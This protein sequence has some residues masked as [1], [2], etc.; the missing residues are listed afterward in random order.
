MPS[1]SE[2]Q[3]AVTDQGAVVRKLKESKAS[4]EELAVAIAE[5]KI[6]KSAVEAAEKKEAQCGPPKV[7]KQKFEN[8]MKRRFFYGPAFSLYGGVAG[9]YDY[10]PAGCAMKANMVNYWRNH[11]VVEEN[12]LEVEST[13]L[14]PEY[15]LKASGHVDRFCDFMV[16][17]VKTGDCYRADHLLEAHLEKLIEAKGTSMEKKEEMGSV[18]RQIDNYGLKEIGE[19]MRLYNCKAPVTNNELS[20]PAE[21]N[22]MFPTSIGPTGMLKGFMR[23]E[24]AQ[25]IFVNFKRLLEYNQDK[26]PFAGAQIGQSFRNEIAPRSGL[27]RVRE[28]CQAEIEHFIDP[29]DKTHPKFKKIKE[30]PVKF[31]SS[32]A[33]TSGTEVVEM[34]VGA[35]LDQGIIQSQTMG[36]FI[37]RIHQYLLAVGIPHTNLRFRQHM[38]NEMA[39][40]AC[41]C[42]DAECKTSYGWVEIVGCAD[43]SCFDLNAHAKATSHKLIAQKR[44]DEPI[45]VDVVEVTVNKAV[46]GKAFKKESGTVTTLLN[47]LSDEDKLRMKEKLES[48][49]TYKLSNNGT[50]YEITQAMLTVAK[51]SKT[52]H[53]REF[54]PSVIEPSF[55]IGRILY[56]I[57]ETN[58]KVREN[59]E[60]RTWLDLPP[61]IAPTKCSVLPLSTHESF[62]PYVE[63]LSA[64]LRSLGIPNKVDDS[65]GAIGRRYARTDEIGIPFGITV[66]FDTVK[67]E[68]VTVR[69]RNSCSQVRVPMSEV[70]TLVQK[71][72]SDKLTWAGAKELYPEFTSQETI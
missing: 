56:C 32:I 5:L 65:S 30:Q 52:S 57:L 64:E 1:L 72:C 22:L 13:M 25:G 63:K 8:C 19:Y 9:L 60:K 6:R 17:D 2:L 31:Y 71:L 45:T 61:L 33:Q 18:L 27:L 24:T 26:I 12:M 68:T 10:G 51:A 20:D 43:R 46:L 62:V 42:W 21:F 54:V 3:S 28:F 14:T 4:A 34:S 44:L 16:K 53:V 49:D 37:A 59:D 70:G 58:F 50:S 66:D 55:G 11:F 7:D 39:H 35:A 23:P 69:E 40:Y 38:P 41:D 15:V 67:L 29:E 48:G 36:Y 47:D